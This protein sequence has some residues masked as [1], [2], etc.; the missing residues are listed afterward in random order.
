MTPGYQ[1][2]L[3]TIRSLTAVPQSPTE[4]FGQVL[5][6]IHD[7][8]PKYQWVGVY[9]LHGENLDLGPYVGAATEHTRIPVGRGVCG[10]AVLHERNQLVEDVSTQSNYL[11]C[12][13]TVRAEIVVLVWQGAKLLGLIDADS[14]AVGAFT[15]EDER[16]LQQVAELLAPTLTKLLHKPS[17]EG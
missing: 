13:P 4:T 12:S 15:A 11:S 16:F 7:R 5:R 17:D 1:S 2:A 14:D 8:L 9:V 6:V 10:A 3:D